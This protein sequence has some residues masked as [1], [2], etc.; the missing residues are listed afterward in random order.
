MSLLCV[1]VADVVG[2]LLLALSS[3]LLLSVLLLDILVTVVVL[4]FV[5]VVGCVVVGNHAA[6]AVMIVVRVVGLA[7]WV[8]FLDMFI[9][10]RP[11][12]MLSLLEENLFSIWGQ[13]AFGL[14]W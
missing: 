12:V 8:V 11:C 5:V 10:R 6:V 2:L 9:E 13:K 14:F 7:F 3:L 4:V 1:A